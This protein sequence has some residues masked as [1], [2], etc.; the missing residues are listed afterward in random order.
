MELIC[1]CSIYDWI[2]YGDNFK[3]FI[4][5]LVISLL[6]VLTAFI[7]FRSQVIIAN[8]ERKDK[9][10]LLT[11]MIGSINKKAVGRLNEWAETLKNLHDNST[12]EKYQFQP[13]NAFDTAL[14]EPITGLSFG[15][16][17]ELCLKHL[18]VNTAVLENYWESIS[19]LSSQLDRLVGHQ[20]NVTDSFNFQNEKLNKATRE[21]FTFIN[22]LHESEIKETFFKNLSTF[23]EKQYENAHLGN[24]QSFLGDINQTLKIH[25]ITLNL[26]F[27]V[28][29]N[30]ALNIISDI[31]T[32]IENFSKT[33]NNY[34]IILIA[35]EANV[36]AFQNE[37]ESLPKKK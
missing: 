20:K 33:V 25:P 27:H 7:I 2:I 24:I 3:D 36:E 19:S 18:K 16:V 35:A 1:V 5:P 17:Y 29:I 28:Q 15:V 14:F 9:Y 21:I 13:I 11:D 26:E 32:L 37:I 30:D 23:Y 31:E 22:N 34:I 4:W 12:L 6:G 10:N 8:R